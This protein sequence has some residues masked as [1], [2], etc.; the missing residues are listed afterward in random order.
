[1]NA[2]NNTRNIILISVSC[3]MSLEVQSG[4]NLPSSQKLQLWT[5][6]DIKPLTEIKIIFLVLLSAFIFLPTMSASSIS[7]HFHIL[8][9]IPNLKN[10][11]TFLRILSPCADVKR[12]SAHIFDGWNLEKETYKKERF[13]FWGIADAP[14]DLY[15]L[16]EEKKFFRD[17]HF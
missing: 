14:Q 6:K 13:F 3:L 2:D 15:D 12:D 10:N 7:E 9:W 8:T 17:F 5:S 1:M 11:W 16:S 4:K